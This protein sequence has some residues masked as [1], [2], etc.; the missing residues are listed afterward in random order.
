MFHARTATRHRLAVAVTTVLAVTA[1]TAL[2]TAAHAAPAAFGVT[3]AAP[4]SASAPASATQDDG[5]RDGR[6][7]LYAVGASDSKFYAGTGDRAAPFKPAAAGSLLSG[8]VPA[9][10]V[11]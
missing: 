1:G 7:D 10:T 11:F 4:S 5:D 9:D 3:P 6:I 2:T 8:T